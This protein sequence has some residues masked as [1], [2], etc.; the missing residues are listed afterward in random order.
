[1]AVTQQSSAAQRPLRLAPNV[2]PRFYAGGP[3][4]AAF[5]GIADVG[6]HAGEDWVGSAATARG[7]KELGLARVPGGA[8]LRDCIAADPEEFLGPEHV[9]AYGADP[10]LLVKLLDAGERLPVHAHPARSFAKEHVGSRWGK[11]EAWIVLETTRPN[12]CVYV[13][14]QRPI[15]DGTLGRW[16]DG[17]RTDEL[18]AA[19][20]R[21]PVEAGDAILIPGGVPHSIGEGVF[22]VEVQEPTDFSVILEWSGYTIDAPNVGHML[23]GY[24]T[25]RQAI[26]RSAWDADRLAALR[27]K[28]SSGGR[29]LPEQADAFFGA[30]WI[31]GST[32]A[33][34]APCFSVLIVTDG[35]GTLAGD[36][37]SESI[38]RG[39]TWL[40][41]Y[42]AGRVS[43]AG[44]VSV[45]R[46]IPPNPASAG[47]GD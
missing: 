46:C 28:R 37:F 14:F 19:L 7:Q 18:L 13:G 23:L 44:D 36:G 16:I 41:P 20:N 34:L 15:D 29:L 27:G 12:A 2:I 17:Q 40:V 5:R 42:A 30:T 22:L 43:I 24:E 4:I 21:I 45:L 9:A 8:F 25:A 11:T 39:E 1:M 32:G 10:G 35:T 26:D 38:A 6:D 31:D 33:T 3:R 47:R